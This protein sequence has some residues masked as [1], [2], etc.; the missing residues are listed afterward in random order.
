MFYLLQDQSPAAVLLQTLC[1]ENIP[2]KSPVAFPHLALIRWI[3][4]ELITTFKAIE[5]KSLQE[6]WRCTFQLGRYHVEPRNT[7]TQLYFLG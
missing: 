4:L 6:S 2:G 5:R 1:A 3:H 7:A